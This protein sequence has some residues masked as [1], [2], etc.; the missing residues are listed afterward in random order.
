MRGIVHLT[1]PK[2]YALVYGQGRS[3]ASGLVILKALP[4]GLGFSRYGI[5]VG[6]HVGNAVTRNRVKRRLREILRRSGI[7]QGW[8]IVLVTRSS[9]GSVRYTD[10][11][12][13][14]EYVLHQAG[15][16]RKAGAVS[17]TPRL[18]A[19]DSDSCPE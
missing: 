16:A 10:L 4:N 8:D 2:Q 3:W 11:Q 13:A 18:L 14:T 1:K 6:K 15:L 7:V 5:S 19:T 9:A 12:K 17:E